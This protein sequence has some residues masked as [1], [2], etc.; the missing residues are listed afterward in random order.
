MKQT[1][2]ILWGHLEYK[3]CKQ[4]LKAC[5]LRHG[6]FPYVEL[7]FGFRQDFWNYF[8]SSTRVVHFA[9]GHFGEAIHNMSW[10]C[11]RSLYKCL[12]RYI[13][14]LFHVVV[15]GTNLF[16]NEQYSIED[17][18]K[19]KNKPSRLNGRWILWMLSPV[20]VV[21]RPN[22]QFF[23]PHKAQGYEAQLKAIPSK[24]Q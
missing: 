14:S 2:W 15:W 13:V 1:R 5:H 11:S 16:E 6:S 17:F 7:R 21:T 3:Q 12:M 10:I 9:K 19:M 23:F 8:A 22:V 20:P 18:L 4:W 24:E